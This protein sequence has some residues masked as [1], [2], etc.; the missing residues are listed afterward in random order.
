M[1][2]S[3]V[4]GVYCT[5]V[6][7]FTATTSAPT[8]TRLEGS[9]T[10]PLRSPLGDCARSGKANVKAHAERR[11]TKGK[12]IRL[13]SDQRGSSPLFYGSQDDPRWYHVADIL[14]LKQIGK[15]S[16]LLNHSEPCTR[17]A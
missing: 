12:R 7:A 2:S 1:P 10:R 8:I 4:F 11:T 16:T 13:S 5:S 14:G 9:T 6:R 3:L 17:A 15:S